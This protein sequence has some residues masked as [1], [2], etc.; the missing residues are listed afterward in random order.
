M[1][2]SFTTARVFVPVLEATLGKE[3]ETPAVLVAALAALTRQITSR[4]VP[5]H[6][7]LVATGGRATARAAPARARVHF[8][9]TSGG[10]DFRGARGTARSARPTCAAAARAAG[11]AAHHKRRAQPA[12]I[13]G[14]I[15]GAPPAL[16]DVLRSTRKLQVWR[17]CNARV[18]EVL[19]SR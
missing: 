16:I 18:R 8:R 2:G 9:A 15:R 1:Q 11:S 10:R 19:Q 6:A 4:H 14:R 13:L 7:L 12:A 17:L 3:D 5:A